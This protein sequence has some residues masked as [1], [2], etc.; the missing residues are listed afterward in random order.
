MIT[1]VLNQLLQP[2][3][4][5]AL[6]FGTVLGTVIGVLPG[7]SAT[8][9]LALLIPVT[10]LMDPI[11]GIILLIA[12]Y[13]SGMYGG[14]ISAILLY[15]PGT[16]S[17]AA[18]SLDGY[19]MTRQG[20]GY[21]AIVVA[22]VSSVTGGLI[23][24]IFLMATGPA[25][26]RVSLAFGPQEYFLVAIFGLTIIGGLAGNSLLRGILAAL[27]GLAVSI[28]G[29][30]A[31]S[32]KQRLTFGSQELQSGLEMIPAMIGLFAVAQ[33]IVLLGEPKDVGNKVPK[34]NTRFRA[35]IPNWSEWRRFSPTIAKS[36]VIGSGV[37][38]LPGAGGD[39]AS[40][41][42]Y[43]EAK[44]SSKRP[45][46]FGT[47]VSEGVAAPE[48]ANNAVVGGSLIPT[49]TLGIPGSAAT[50]VLLGGL[51]M[52]GLVP[53]H[54]L[55][56][57]QAVETYSIISGFMIATVLMGIVG[58]VLARYMV[59]VADAPVGLVAIVITVLS[60]L[61]SFAIRN[62]MFDVLVMLC[63]AG[64]GYALRAMQINAAPVILGII[65]GPIA[66]SGYRQSQTIAGDDNFWLSLLERPISVTL[67]V[68]IG[69]AVAVTFL[70]QRKVNKR[71]RESVTSSAS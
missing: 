20:L 38:L 49:L 44:R 70:Q 56:S 57:E 9:A 31:Q 33:I 53:G 23:G 5:G 64:V 66:E 54:Q 68:L 40:W 25:V 29:I 51:I 22:T 10:F 13:T 43:N 3:T 46:M 71:L 62:S 48:A 17:N 32:G 37:G 30:D 65:L 15:A 41:V 26:A 69:L 6:V 47:G 45:E 2:A 4:I 7:L 42:S 28:V 24:G 59:R 50:A 18:T 55:F 11:P 21:K 14:S 36:S 12:V 16:P 67:L 52:K 39:I 63:F 27:F 61:G 35:A 58:L 34:Q 19:P 8:M 60:V 1:E